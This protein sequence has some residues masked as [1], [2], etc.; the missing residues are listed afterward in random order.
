MNGLNGIIFF[1]I[2]LILSFQND[3]SRDNQNEKRNNISKDE[4]QGKIKGN[5]KRKLSGVN[6]NI[7]F[8]LYNFNYTFPN[9]T[10]GENSK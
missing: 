6:L 9:D 10:L 1:S 2:L 5:S 7:Y 8:D 4:Y 3:N